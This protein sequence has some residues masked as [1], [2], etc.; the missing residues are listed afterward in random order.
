[1]GRAFDSAVVQS[2]LPA[3]PLRGRPV[4]GRPRA[5]RLGPLTADHRAG[6]ALILREVKEVAQNHL[7]EEV[8]RAVITVPA[9]YNER[10]REAVRSAGALAGLQVERILNEPTAAALAYA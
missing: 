5:V 3:I 6:A 2:M 10:Q 9:Y 1:M 4:R 7:G 8:N